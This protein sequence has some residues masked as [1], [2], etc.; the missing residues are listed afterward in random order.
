M[1]LFVLHTHIRRPGFLARKANLSVENPPSG[2][3][4]PSISTE[5]LARCIQ[6]CISSFARF[7]HRRQACND[8]IS[9]SGETA[10]LCVALNT[11]VRLKFGSGVE[12]PKSLLRRTGITRWRRRRAFNHGHRLV[13][14]GFFLM[15]RCKFSAEKEEVKLN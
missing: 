7:T 13:T 5:P 11:Y 12:Q 15:I 10:K 8:V 2:T 6:Y 14:Q 9:D 4:K 1:E 3:R